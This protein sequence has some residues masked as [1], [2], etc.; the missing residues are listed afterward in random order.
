MARRRS[1]S[2]RASNRGPCS[3]SAA[4]GYRTS[5][6][7]AR[8][9]CAGDEQG[10]ATLRV[11]AVS[12]RPR[13]TPAVSIAMAPPRGQ[14]LA[15][16]VQ[17]LAELG[18]DEVVLMQTERTVRA[19][20]PEQAVRMQTRLGAVVREAA[21]QSRQPYLMDVR[22]GGALFEALDLPDPTMVI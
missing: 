22:A 15:W 4:R 10:R 17:K 1:S 3:A 20:K 7:V 2:S 16:A 21:M 6:G 19:W 9:T 12:H 18:V 13:R 5:A 14:R 8:G 11:H